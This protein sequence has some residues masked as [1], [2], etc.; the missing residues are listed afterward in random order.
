MES[1]V[2]R[3]ERAEQIWRD[4]H[5]ILAARAVLA[6]EPHGEPLPTGRSRAACAAWDDLFDSGGG[7]PVLQALSTALPTATA[8]IAGE[9]VTRLGDHDD[10][11]IDVHVVGWLTD[12]P[13]KSRPSFARFWEPVFARLAAKGPAGVD[14]TALA[15]DVRRLR[16]PFAMAL[17]DR[18]A[19][20]EVPA[21]RPL[22]EG[23]RAWLVAE[24]FAEAEE[25]SVGGA[26]DLEALFE[27]VRAD[28]DDR[29]ARSVLAD[30]LQEA[31]DPRGT[32]IAGQLASGV[33][34]ESYRFGRYSTVELVSGDPDVAAPL[35]ELLRAHGDAWLG[36][37]PSILCKVRW[38]DGFPIEAIPHVNWGKVGRLV[39]APSLRTL[40]TFTI[41]REDRRGGVRKVLRSR[42][43][44]NL[45][46]LLGADPSDLKPLG[47]ALPS[48]RRIAL[49]CPLSEPAVVAER[50]ASFPTLE[51]V[52]LT[53]ARSVA[54]WAD[55]DAVGA[56]AFPTLQLGGR[57]SDG[58]AE[59]LPALSERLSPAVETLRLW[60]GVGCFEARR[61]EGFATLHH[62]GTLR[63]ADWKSLSAT[64]PILHEGPVLVERDDLEALPDATDL[65]VDG[66][67][68]VLALATDGK[69]ASTWFAQLPP[70]ERLSVAKVSFGDRRALLEAL[71]P[72]DVASVQLR[73]DVY[74]REA[75]GGP[76]RS[77]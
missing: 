71:E 18:I 32:F 5:H 59:R 20:V 22:T 37:W 19:A 30:A 25:P 34:L 17:A 72:L 40:R 51:H 54:D 10:P 13:F 74:V 41:P 56:L 36:E 11:V 2:D 23:E 39:D 52:E 65:L 43:G 57:R 14:W 7:R 29:V 28:P 1:D 75:P 66:R 15:A 60:T 26:R 3:R 49:P 9:R 48:L 27:A 38:V 61:S 55:A 42:V 24:G 21:R 4:T 63:F 73:S 8:A 44:D 77:A 47:G 69:D 50:L 6:T 68:P 53:H 12:P 31:D 67:F 46:T 16:T 35:L 62:T 33:V 76:F 64:H 45:H 58:L 70:V